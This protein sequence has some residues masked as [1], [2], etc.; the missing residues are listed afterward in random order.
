[1]SIYFCSNHPID[2]FKLSGSVNTAP[3]A[4]W[5]TNY[6]KQTLRC[7][8]EGVSAA[9]EWRQAIPDAVKT[10]FYWQGRVVI[11]SMASLF[12]IQL[13]SFYSGAAGSL[14]ER[15]RLQYSGGAIRLM[16]NNAGTWTQIGGNIAITSNTLY[17]MTV[18][19]KH[20]T[21]TG[22]IEFRLNNAVIGSVGGD[23]STYNPAGEVTFVD[24]WNPSVN[25]GA[26]V[27][28]DWAELVVTVNENPFLMRVKTHVLQANSAVNTGW[29]GDYTYVDEADPS[30]TDIIV[31]AA[32]GLTSTFTIDPLPAIG[33]LV[34]RAVQVTAMARR[35]TTGPAN[36]KLAL[37]ASGV[38]QLSPT[39]A[40]QTGY[41]AAFNVYE[42]NSVTGAE[43]TKAEID[44]SEPGVQSVA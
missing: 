35:G 9:P 8:G 41:N 14:T 44:A 11:G 12:G 16:W 22:I 6:V 27:P 26:T 39:K 5:D 37:R 10:D 15:Y 40:L 4:P 30:S 7:N 17:A 28:I 36:L 33:S 32:A 34:V 25:S 23:T 43:F 13:V 19:F 42:Q 2:F 38:N 3:A 29:T 20:S 21:T 18:Q 1:M 31:A 24:F